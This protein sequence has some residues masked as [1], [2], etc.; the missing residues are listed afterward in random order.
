MGVHNFEYDND[1]DLPAGRM[2]RVQRA[3]GWTVYC[4]FG[5]LLLTQEG[6]ARDFVLR[7]GE[8][9]WI[10][11]HGRVLVEATCGAKLRLMKMGEAP[12][13]RPV[14]R[15]LPRRASAALDRHAGRCAELGP[16][17]YERVFRNPRLMERLVARAHCE[18]DA[19][20]AACVAAAFKG[21]LRL[22]VKAGHAVMAAAGALARAAAGLRPQLPSLHETFAAL[23]FLR[24]RM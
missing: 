6:D 18:R 14:V 13:G 23:V 21:G 3:R 15:V 4:E 10:N 11:T 7:A 20:M 12:L 22:S 19:L 1:Y 16:L 24:S 5:E 8:R 17:N 9:T 2:M